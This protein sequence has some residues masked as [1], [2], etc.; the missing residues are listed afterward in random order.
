[1]PSGMHR[2]EVERINNVHL[3]VLRKD[4]MAVGRVGLEHTT[5]GYE[6]DT[7]SITLI[8]SCLRLLVHDLDMPFDKSPHIYACLGAFS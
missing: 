7:L 5:F 6:V 2:H 3:C 1:M 4:T 8:C